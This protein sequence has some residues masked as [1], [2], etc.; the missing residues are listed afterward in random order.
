[1]E[2]DYPAAHSMDTSWYAVDGKG[3]VALFDTGAGGAVPDRAYSPDMADYLDELPPEVIEAMETP[4][5][6]A[7]DLL[8]DER[9][10]YRYATGDLDECL[11]DRYHR[12]KAP[13]QPIHIDELPPEA[14]ET[15]GRVRFP[16]VDFATAKVLQP[17]ELTDCTA[18]GPAYLASDG[19][20]V[21][22][23]PGRERE[24]GQHV[25]E[26]RSDEPEL[27]F[28]D[29]PQKTPRRRKKKDDAEG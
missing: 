17:I 13:K 26:M 27:V 22:A 25:E 4:N 7:P 5:V 1:M 8:P 3:N 6:L 9:R 23:V 15:I 24:Y 20:T 16:T 29:P 12:K 11:A 14:R 21:R 19:K 2:F 18:W 10:V 28:E